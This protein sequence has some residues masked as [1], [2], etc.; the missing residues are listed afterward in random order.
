ME[1]YNV[2]GCRFAP[3]YPD[4]VLFTHNLKPLSLTVTIY[5]WLFLNIEVLTLKML[6]RNFCVPQI[7]CNRSFYFICKDLES[8]SALTTPLAIPILLKVQDTP[9]A[10][11]MYC[12]NF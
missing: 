6:C 11:T 5:H 8:G 3:F 10:A 4:Y 2:S 1:L 9:L 12:D 7:K